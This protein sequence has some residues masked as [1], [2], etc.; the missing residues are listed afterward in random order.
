MC[1][2]GAIFNNQKARELLEKSLQ[3]VR[4]RGNRRLETENGKHFALGANRLPIVDRVG[5]VQ[6]ARNESSNLL[7]VFNG[8][9]FNYRELRKT[10]EEKGH[11]FETSSDTEVLVHLYEEHGEE[12]LELIDSEMYAF[13]IYDKNKKEYFAAR[14][15]IGVKP[16]YWA[17]T[18]ETEYFASEMKQLV[19]F[20]DIGEIRVVYPGH[21]VK[22]GRA[23]RYSDLM[24][25]KETSTENPGQMSEKVRRLLHEA[26]RKRVQTDLP[27]G[28]F[29]SGG[30]D[31]TSVLALAR[32][33]HNNITA[34]IA[35]K[36]DSADV[37][38]AKKYCEEF[39]VPYM[40]VEPSTEEELAD[41]IERIVYITET[42]EPN[43]VRQSVISFYVSKLGR[44]FRVILCGEGADEIFA[45]YPEFEQ[46]G[47]KEITNLE[48][49]FLRDLHRTQLQRVDRTSM[50]FTE[51]VRA[52]FLDTALV[53]YALSIPAKFKVR[54]KIT[55]WILRKAMESELPDY[56]CW[57]KK[58]VM[59][60]GAGYKGNGPN[61]GMFD[62]FIDHRMDD[63]EFQQIKNRFREW[64]IRSKEE[65]YYFR[66]FKEFGFDKGRFAK[67][68][69]RVN[70]TNSVDRSVQ[71]AL[72]SQKFNRYEPYRIE[73]VNERE[74]RF[75]MFWGA[76]GK[77]IADDRDNETIRF[78][79]EYRRRIEE[80]GGKVEIKVLLAD[81]HARMNGID[82]LT[83]YTYLQNVKELLEKKGFKVEYLSSLW[84]KWGLD[85]TTINRDADAAKITDGKLAECL[86][87]ASERYFR[88]DPEQGYKV[89]Y[90]MRRKERK[91]LEHEFKGHV[92]LT[93]NNPL[94]R[95][96]LPDM[97]TLHIRSKKGSSKP[98]WIP[99][100]PI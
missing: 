51:E 30:I 55:K 89:Y 26:V 1:G 90:I 25:K 34:L 59:S 82:D 80:S 24:D 45:G 58:V 60:E 66:I 15:R 35:G 54:D 41:M 94:F 57:R 38:H 10:L 6:P 83:T 93:F 71:R 87:R 77:Q 88:G 39:D 96:I 53:D 69:V 63:N 72:K 5:A 19:Q 76:L 13:V 48:I 18:N 84:K 64:D 44:D 4:H 98:P 12:M 33:Y 73:E 43:V 11:R 61:S 27:I 32:K 79:N 75:V 46:V 50:R 56:I 31:S 95:E 100:K 20:P 37:Y 86:R 36:G 78:L 28:V 16:L 23:S 62:E 49:E 17:K 65:A 21:Y 92:F 7:C 14:D 9:I 68:R 29:L 40:I 2:I 91:H 22:N 85:K 67:K 8:E 74:L 70:L 97:P 42:F 52:P 47:K 3:K 99:M 81:S